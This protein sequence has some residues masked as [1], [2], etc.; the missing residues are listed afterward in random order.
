MATTKIV[1]TPEQ[2][3]EYCKLMFENGYTN[4]Q[5]QELCGA[6]SSAITR[7]K[8]QYRRELQGEAPEA[9]RAFTTNCHQSVRIIVTNLNLRCVITKGT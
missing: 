7:W 2:K 6:S 8:R 5:I 1:I 3:L 9:G 4:K